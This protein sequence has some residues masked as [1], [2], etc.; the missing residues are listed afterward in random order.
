AARVHQAMTNLVGNAVLHGTGCI[1][2][3]AS[4]R[5]ARVL[6]KVHNLGAETPAERRP[7]F[8]EPFRKKERSTGL[9]LGLYI[10]RE[11]IRRHGG[12]I[13]VRSHPERG[14]PLTSYWPSAGIAPVG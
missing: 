3:M 1:R 4:G 7:C 9:G 10:V 5:R 6:V 8:F 2:V 11:I 13:H 14:T 12:T